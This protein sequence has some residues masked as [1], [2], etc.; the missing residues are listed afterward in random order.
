[1]ERSDETIISY[2]MDSQRI[3]KLLALPLEEEN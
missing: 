3:G 2:I 1:M